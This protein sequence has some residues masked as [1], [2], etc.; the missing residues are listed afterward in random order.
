M[1]STENGWNEYSRLVLEQLEALSDGIE[2]LRTEMQELRQELTIMKAK[3]SQ[4][5]ELKM[6]KEKIEDFA[7]PRQMRH[8][9]SEIEELKTFKT[10]AVTIFM[11]VQ[12]MMALV[13][14][15]SQIL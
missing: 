8:A 14:A 1:A 10:K 2:G 15:W 6:W 12:T 9:L 13:I 11:V 4:V 5:A 7:S 3:E